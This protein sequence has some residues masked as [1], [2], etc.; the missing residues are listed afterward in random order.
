M[1]HAMGG[2][3]K[4]NSAGALHYAG[5]NE[6]GAFNNAQMQPQIQATNSTP[7]YGVSL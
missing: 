1:R 7:Q 5:N 4:T 3:H 2:R 6:S